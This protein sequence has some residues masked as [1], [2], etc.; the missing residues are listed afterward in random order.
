[1]LNKPGGSLPSSPK[2][3]TLAEIVGSPPGEELPLTP[4]TSERGHGG[5]VRVKETLAN[6]STSWLDDLY[7]EVYRDPCAT[8]F[9]REMPTLTEEDLTSPWCPLANDTQLI[10]RILETIHSLP[11][12]LLRDRFKILQCVHIAENGMKYRVYPDDWP[13]SSEYFVANMCR[14]YRLL[15]AYEMHIKGK[16]RDG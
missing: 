11:R 15:P 8:I 1:M 9:K 10:M 2:L 4:S 12:R 14:G 5:D 16:A 7:L 6:G 3:R 13:E